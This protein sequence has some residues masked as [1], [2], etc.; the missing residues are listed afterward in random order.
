MTKTSHRFRGGGCGCTQ[1]GTYGG[2]AASDAVMHGITHDQLAM[3][4][5]SGI[6]PLVSGGGWGLFGRPMF[7]GGVPLRTPT[8]VTLT[9]GAKRKTTRKPASKKK[10][11]VAKKKTTTAAKK[12]KPAKKSKK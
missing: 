2:S 9:G 12:K 7:T 4:Q 1:G 8:P 10:T 11:L 3:A 5:D 6:G